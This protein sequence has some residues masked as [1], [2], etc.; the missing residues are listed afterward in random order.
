[1]SNQ[2]ATLS[3]STSIPES[4]SFHFLLLP[5]PPASFGHSVPAVLPMSQLF[6]FYRLVPRV[7]LS[8]KKPGHLPQR[9]P[10][11]FLKASRPHHTL[12]WGRDGSVDGAHALRTV[13]HFTEERVG[14]QR[15]TDTCLKSHSQEVAELCLTQSL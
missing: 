14:L 9:A 15:G 10:G 7:V 3:S 2:E 12:A 1:M 13:P 6:L 11:L 4:T 8:L 5:L